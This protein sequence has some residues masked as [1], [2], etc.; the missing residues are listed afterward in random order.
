MARQRALYGQYRKG[1]EVRGYE[2]R[3]TLAEFRELTNS[4]CFYCGVTGG[5]LYKYTGAS[6]DFVGNGVDRYDNAEG[7][8]AENSVPCCHRCNFAKAQMRGDEFLAMCREVTAH[9]TDSPN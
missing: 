7:Y 3:L 6:G 8:T 4:P 2:F 9:H 5:H 1:A